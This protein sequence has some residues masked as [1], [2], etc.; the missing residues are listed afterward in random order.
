MAYRDPADLDARIAGAR[1]FGLDLD[2]AKNAGELA[3]AL[4]GL[5]GP[6]M[7][8]AQLMATIPDALPPEYTA[9]LAKLQSQAPPMGWA[10]VKRR[11]SAELGVENIIVAADIRKTVADVKAFATGVHAGTVRPP[12]VPRFT[13]VLSIGIGGSALG[14]MFVADALGN[15]DADRMRVDFIDNTD[16][17]GIDRVLRLLAGRLGETL[18]IVTSKSGGTPETRN[19]M[20]LVAEA[21]RAA[22]LEFPVDV[23][24]E[25]QPA[26]TRALTAAGRIDVLT[27]PVYLWRVRDDGTS[28]SQQ[29]SDPRDLSDRIL[30]KRWSTATV[31]E[32]CSPAT[33][34]VWFRRVLPIDMWEHFRAAV[35]PDTEDPC[36]YWELLR[37]AVLEFWYDAG[38]PFED[39][40]VPPVQ[41]LMA[42][43]VAQDRAEDL[44][45][46]IG[47]IDRYGAGK[48][49]RQHPW[50][51]DPALPP[52][53]RDI[54]K[55]DG[56]ALL[57][58]QP[59]RG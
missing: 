24:Y 38:V 10:F 8:V 58:R 43:L 30:T 13:R 55:V 22:G 21:Y 9:E 44:A 34:D 27:D 49:F 52:Q 3:A 32:A 15:P 41:R 14:P 28:I 57:T 40:T 53:L 29:R 39:T 20:L 42:W 6:I 4:G 1:F 2:R 18:C 48:A 50:R 35:H 54:E 56:S 5:K 47:M 31:A 37:A 33:R 59:M 36:R 25:D 7:K 46:L 23:R 51:E 16:P 26:L 45:A 17:D 19:G 11:M 12:A